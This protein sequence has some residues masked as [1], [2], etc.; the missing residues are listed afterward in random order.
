[1]SELDSKRRLP[2][3]RRLK[4]LHSY[5]YPLRP[6]EAGLLEAAEL[7]DKQ[8][9]RGQPKDRPAERWGYENLIGVS[10]G[11]KLVH[12][13]R[14]RIRAIVV[15]VKAK[16]GLTRVPPAFQIPA[17]INGYLTDL[18]VLAEPVATIGSVFSKPHRKAQHIVPA[19]VCIGVPGTQVC[20]TLGCFVNRETKLFLLT[21]QHV[22]AAIPSAPRKGDQV[23]HPAP[24]VKVA[25]RVIG[26]VVEFGG[27]DRSTLTVTSD[28]GL[29]EVEPSKVTPELM[30][31]G[32]IG[33]GFRPLEHKLQV[34]KSGR[35]TGVT[36]GIVSHFC[37]TT[38]VWYGPKSAQTEYLVKGAWMVWTGRFKGAFAK[39]G[40][41]GAL[42]VEQSESR[43]PV[44]FLIAGS[45]GRAFVVPIQQV[46]SDANAELVR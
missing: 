3:K 22:L 35:S 43:R 4:A 9:F 2:W 23:H 21:A 42:V 25:G 17:S 16:A 44:A 33:E 7:L 32:K 45:K 18:V 12:G 34:R 8:L 27:I 36:E 5:R 30:A 15:F 14:T 13:R 46:L 10:V 24:S 11:E 19:G 38:K 20:G 39:G 29:A 28:W 31:M 6:I 1:M 26:T 41:S 37:L 40:D